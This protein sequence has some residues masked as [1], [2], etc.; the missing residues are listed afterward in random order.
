M[1]MYVFQCLL[2]RLAMAGKAGKQ[3]QEDDHT[4]SSGE[5]AVSWEDP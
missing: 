5:T 3:D 4:Q 2:L 1:C